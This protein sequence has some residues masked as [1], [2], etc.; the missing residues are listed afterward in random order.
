M[1][2][3]S[4]RLGFPCEARHPLGIGRKEVRQNLDGDR[5][6]EVR[7]D[8]A[9]DLPHS[10]LADLGGDLI[11]TEACRSR[12]GDRHHVEPTTSGMRGCEKRKGQARCLALRRSL[13]IE[14]LI[15]H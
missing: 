3:R 15:P 2:Q 5:S 13:A 6:S 8:R 9:I 11:G 10:A 4:E 7:I 1:V 12:S 14:L